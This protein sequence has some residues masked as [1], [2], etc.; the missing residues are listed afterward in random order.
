MATIGLLGPPLAHW[1]G[2]P[3]PVF[4]EFHHHDAKDM[5][6]GCL[7]RSGAAEVDSAG[8]VSGANVASAAS[9]A[10]RAMLFLNV[11]LSSVLFVPGN[12]VDDH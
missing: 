11:R 5:M 1:H 6:D 2:R 3:A 8:D 4:S 10:E 12:T 9:M 7:W